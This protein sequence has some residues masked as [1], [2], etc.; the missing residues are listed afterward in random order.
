VNIQIV[1][2]TT[3]TGLGS[4]I[5]VTDCDQEITFSTECGFTVQK[6]TPITTNGSVITP[7]PTVKRVQTLYLAPWQ[8]MTAGE[9]PS[10]VDVKICSD[11]DD[12]DMECMRYQ[13]VWEVV[14]VTSTMTKQHTVQISTT[15]S[16]PGTLIVA[17][18]TGIYTDTIE[19]IDLSTVLLLETE[20]ETESISSGR[21]PTATVSSTCSTNLQGMNRLSSL[22]SVTDSRSTPEPTSTL[23]VTSTTKTHLSTMTV[24]RPR[25]T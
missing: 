24:T 16:G 6:A 5:P 2:A 22:A 9:T 13:E 25:P 19:S 15:V 11:L 10:D 18:A 8:S 20:I 21:K 12:D 4:K 1:C 3:L 23:W 17:K 14:V 7:A